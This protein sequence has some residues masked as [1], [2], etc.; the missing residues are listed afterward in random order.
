[1]KLDLL[2]VGLMLF[3][4]VLGLV[5]GAAQQVAH[6]GGV[7]AGY[8]LARPVGS[9]LGPFLARQLGFPPLLGIVISSV[10]GFFAVYTLTH[11]VVR[12]IVK[13]TF[14]E[15]ARGAADRVGGLAI[16]LAKSAVILWVILSGMMLVEK[17]LTQM[18]LKFLGDTKKSFFASFA[19]EHNLLTVFGFPGVGGLERMLKAARD[20]AHAADV[21]KSPEYQIL[22]KDPR[23]REALADEKIARALQEGDVDALLRSTKILDLLNDPQVLS[24]L[25]DL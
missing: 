25:Q 20:P 12:V 11:V 10:L 23:L 9:L 22:S 7:I 17:T 15:H 19:R 21:L 8:L 2:C 16:G 6:L 4:G 5:S 13:R 18:G 24:R 14:G 1:M 3:F